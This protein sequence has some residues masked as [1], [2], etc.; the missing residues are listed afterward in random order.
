MILQLK[1]SVSG[2]SSYVDLYTSRIQDQLKTGPQVKKLSEIQ[3]LIIKLN[4]SLASLSSKMETKLQDA[5]TQQDG[6]SSELKRFLDRLNSS[7]SE[8]TAKL[9]DTDQKV[10]AGL[11][12]MKD[13]LKISSKTAVFAQESQNR[14]LAEVVKLSS[15]VESL[16][17]K[18]QST[19]QKVMAALSEMKAK[20]ESCS[21]TA[22]GGSTCKPGWTPQGC[23]CYFFSTDKLNWHQARDYCRS[24]SASL[25]KLETKDEWVFVTAR[26]T[27]QHYWVGLTDED[28]GQ[29]RWTDGTPYVM[30]KDDWEVGQ[31]DDWK[32][33]GL[34]EEGEDCGHLKA[35][36][37]FNDAHCSNSMKYIC[38]A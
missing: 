36:G 22:E 20:L 6:Q 11:S 5:G 8:L 32:N 37:K 21:K 38:K 7:I 14:T 18:L 4:S 29:W 28:T 25:L 16:S 26:T 31:P 24:Q 2:L 30:N 3:I 33:H 23:K 10:M 27:L 19:D 12:E 34:G 1:T 13:K 17:S 9:Q 15:S 35:A